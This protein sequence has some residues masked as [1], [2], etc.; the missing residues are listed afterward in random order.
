MFLLP[1][2]SR[3]IQMDRKEFEEK[4]LKQQY[5]LRSYYDFGMGILWIAAG[6]FFLLHRKLGMEFDFEPLMSNVFG[7]ACILY[8]LFRIRRGFKLKQ[9]G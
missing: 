5:R 1:C 7:G 6:I 8:G 9:A 3:K 2:Q 4:Q